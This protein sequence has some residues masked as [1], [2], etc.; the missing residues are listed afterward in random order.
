MDQ[1]TGQTGRLLVLGQLVSLVVAIKK[2]PHTQMH[3]HK[4]T[5]QGHTHTLGHTLTRSHTHQVAHIPGYT[6]LW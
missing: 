1:G 5:Q 6:A 4:V 3:T 2:H